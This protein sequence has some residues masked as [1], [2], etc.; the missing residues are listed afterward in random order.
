MNS[1]P[2]ESII[3]P[4]GNLSLQIMCS[5]VTWFKFLHASRAANSEQ[6]GW[7][8]K[9]WWNK[10]GL[11]LLTGDGEAKPFVTTWT[12]SS[13]R[14]TEPIPRKA[15]FM[16][17]ERHEAYLEGFRGAKDVPK[18][19]TENHLNWQ[20]FHWIKAEFDHRLV[21]YELPLAGVS[22]GQLKADLVTF[23]RT[24]LVEIIE[25]KRTGAKGADSPL[26]ALVEAICYTLQLLRC[27]E[28]LRAELPP[29]KISDSGIQKVNIVLAAPNY[30]DDCKAGKG[31]ERKINDEDA[32]LLQ[33]IVETVGAAIKHNPH[34]LPKPQL[35]LTLA[36]ILDDGS[37]GMTM[38]A[39]KFTSL[40]N[41]PPEGSVVESES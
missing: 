36:E 7:N 32:K 35:T 12:E 11:K 8:S 23:D 6:D 25:L 41:S 1:D 15:D 17:S 40:K 9:T 10:R 5:E 24:G 31:E 39:L 2:T 3:K 27:W 28:N 20:I 30:W 19:G 13:L 38:K 18:E 4:N 37:G 33:K 16:L 29:E 26:M 34:E 14:A 22:C 21:T